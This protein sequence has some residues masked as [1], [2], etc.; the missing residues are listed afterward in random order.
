MIQSYDDYKYYLEAD[1]LSMGEKRVRPQ[2]IGQD[3]WKFQ[4]LLRKLEYYQNCK[5]SI[6]YKPIKQ[7]LTIKFHILSVRLGF[8][9]PTNVFGPGLNIA[10]RGTIIVNG[11]SKIGKNCRVH[12]CVNIGTKGGYTNIAPTIGDNVYIGPGVKIFGDINIANGVAIGANA[13]VNKSFEEED[14][15]IAGVPARKI[16]NKGSECLIIR[17][18]EI[19]AGRMEKTLPHDNKRR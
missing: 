15:S 9:I 5:R 4:R 16:S 13:V 7:I 10:H 8:S 1:R 12:A 11:F 2:L 18:T 17:G 3:V 6:L 19:L 14:I